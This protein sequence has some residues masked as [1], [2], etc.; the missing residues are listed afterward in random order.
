MRVGIIGAGITGLA[1][2]HYLAEHEVDVVT[3]DSAQEPGGVIRSEAVNGAV[4]ENGPQRIRLTPAVSDLIDAVGM[5]DD[6]L[7]AN[8]DLPLYVYANGS[9]REVPR[10]I[11]A[12]LRTDLLSPKAK[13]RILYEPL[14]AQASP[15][16]H[17]AKL[18]QRKFGY[19]AYRN[20]IEP[21]FGGTFGS[22]PAA[23]PAKYSLPQLIQLEKDKGSLLRAAID[24]IRS[25][26]ETP[27]PVSFKSGLQTL[28]R[29]LYDHHKPYVHLNSVV[30]EIKSLDDGEYCVTAGGRDIIVD[31]VVVTIPAK[32][33]ASILDSV[34]D[35]EVKPLRYLAYNSLVIVHLQA[36]C[37]VNGFG[38]QVRRD[39]SLETLGVS[40][41]D[42]L[43][44]RNGVYTVFLGGMHNP[45][46]IQRTVDDIGSVAVAEFAD[47]MD[48]E[49]SVL[50]VT[51]LPAA[52]PAHDTTWKYRDH[53]S[54][55]ENIILETNYTAR[56]GVPSRIRRA[57][58]VANEIIETDP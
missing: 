40:W 42:S 57:K 28:P 38:Y 21:L 44:G 31:T 3:V 51:K 58:Q 25:N 11:Q 26:A 2:T 16:E 9:L 53:V 52:F 35:A 37:D 46:I 22:D 7:I 19:E 20:L 32:A 33:A 36:D 23:M 41:N 29:A 30:D 10:S 55:P 49:A 4:I 24:R 47:V 56:M 13:A 34:P 1:L 18:F 27:P 5:S 17:A 6:L 54:L 8:D 45:G 12:F 14:T 50:N 15:D 39:E 48:A 43:F